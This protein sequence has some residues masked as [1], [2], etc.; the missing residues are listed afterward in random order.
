MFTVYETYAPVSRLPLIRA[1][2]AIIN[3]Y[4]YDAY[5]LDVKTAF[6]NGNLEEEI[7]VEVLDGYECEEKTKFTKVCK[8]QK[9]LYGLKIRPKN[10]MIDSQKSKRIGFRK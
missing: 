7:Y 3:K 1:V 8:L 5:Q 4:D 2:L 10:G 6:V 9:S